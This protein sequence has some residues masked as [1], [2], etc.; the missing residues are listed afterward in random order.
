MT[1]DDPIAT[2]G[3]VDQEAPAGHPLAS[4]VQQ[5]PPRRDSPRCAP[6]LIGLDALD[7][8]ALARDAELRLSV[9][10]WETPIGPWGMVLDQ[11]PSPGAH[12]RR[13]SPIRIVVSGR[14]QLRLPDLRGLPLQTATDELSW[15]GFVP[16]VDGRRATRSVP[17]GHVVSSRPAAGTLTAHGSVVALTVARTPIEPPEHPP[18]APDSGDIEA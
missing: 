5:A 11:Q 2:P 16:L 1:L 9:A 15:L 17:A 4:A 6:D 12:V 18:A 10:V 13:G 8:H 14:P 7:A 3:L